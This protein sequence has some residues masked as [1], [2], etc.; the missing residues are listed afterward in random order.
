MSNP[1][2]NHSIFWKIIQFAASF[3]RLD[4]NRLKHCELITNTG[5]NIINGLLMHLIFCNFNKSLAKAVTIK[6]RHKIMSCLMICN[7]TLI[8][9]TL[10]KRTLEV[11]VIVT[12]RTQGAL[13]YP[14]LLQMLQWA[15]ALKL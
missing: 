9:L 11:N 5:I 7:W 2:I 6:C 1:E 10:L 8:T 4:Q 3:S 15:A 14:G 13:L 12:E